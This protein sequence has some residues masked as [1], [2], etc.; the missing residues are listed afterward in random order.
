MYWITGI[1]GLVLMIAPF[2]AGYANNPAALWSSMVLGLIV[3]AVSIYKGVT[4]DQAR[5]EY[6]VVAI[7]GLLAVFA[8]FIFGFSAVTVALWTVIA[9]GGLMAF[10][11][12]YEGFF[13]S[14]QPK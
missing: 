10:V 6:I 1:L 9:I 13:A 4:H 11:G 8:P 5:W 14:P 12:G 3:L 7:A 2:L